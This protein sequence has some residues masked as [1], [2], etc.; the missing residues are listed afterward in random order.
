MFAPNSRQV[1]HVLRTRSPLGSRKSPVRLACVKRAAS[2]RPEPGSNSPK[3]VNLVALYDEAGKITTS[4]GIH[5]SLTPSY[6]PRITRR[7]WCLLLTRKGDASTFPLSL[8]PELSI[9]TM[10]RDSTLAPYSMAIRCFTSQTAC[11][12]LGH[13]L[14]SEPS[15][16]TPSERPVK[17]WSVPLDL[18]TNVSVRATAFQYRALREEVKRAEAPFRKDLDHG[19]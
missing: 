14:P 13:R 8:R 18:E 7:T 11:F 15:S 12:P 10:S 17:G 9:P 5:V 3:R 16:L 1:A 2:V 4:F 6:L 19:P